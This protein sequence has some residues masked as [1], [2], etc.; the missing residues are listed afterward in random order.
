MVTT[1]RETAHQRDAT[2][3]RGRAAQAGCEAVTP[4]VRL[5]GVSKF[6]GRGAGRIVALDAVS[7]DVYS[8]QFM[9]VL[10]PS[11]SGKTTLVQIA[12]GLMSPDEGSVL[13][14][15]R[16]LHLRKDKA[17]SRLR[18]EE[19]GFVFQ[20]A[21]LAPQLS[22]R[23]N[24]ELPMTI[25]GIRRRAR[26]ARAIRCLESVGLSGLMDRRVGELSGGQQQ[27]VGIARALTRRPGLLF[28]D[29]PTGNLD[30]RRGGEIVDLLT[31]LARAQQVAVVMVTHNEAYACAADRVVQMLDGRLQEVA[32]APR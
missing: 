26:R 29:E 19:L 27:R 12:S 32:R 15:G 1:T 11:G 4:I 3:G 5:E 17:V 18:N 10:G 2:V 25:A 23:E 9:V 8:G 20:K 30:T 28:A 6:Y 13:V 21:H 31:G 14:A 24:V 22:V 16:P 7:L